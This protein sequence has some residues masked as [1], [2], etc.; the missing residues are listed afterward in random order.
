MLYLYGRSGTTTCNPPEQR[1]DR[2]F[3]QQRWLRRGRRVRG[4]RLSARVGRHLVSWN[5]DSGDAD[6]T[7]I[8]TSRCTPSG[9]ADM[10]PFPYLKRATH[11]L[12]AARLGTPFSLGLRAQLVRA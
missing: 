9:G 3:R 8:C 10:N 7:T 11:P 5:G 12:F 1:P 4:P 2:A 6:G